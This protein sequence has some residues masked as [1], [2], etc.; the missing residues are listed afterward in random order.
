MTPNAHHGSDGS[1]RTTG[2]RSFLVGAVRCVNGCNMEVSR[3]GGISVYRNWLV[4]WLPSILFS[5]IL[6]II[7][8]ID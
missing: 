5:H 7:I 8:P 6:G 4:V 2:G 1:N 3:K